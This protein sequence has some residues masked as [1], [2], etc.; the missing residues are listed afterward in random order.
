M[1]SARKILPL[2]FGFVIL[3]PL[4]AFATTASCADRTAVVETLEERFGEAYFGNMESDDGE[5]LEIYSNDV[6]QTWTILL[7]LPDR[8]LSCLV[9]S[10]TGDTPLA[11]QLARLEN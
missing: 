4:G 9:A 6:S 8:G 7:T 10:G 5:V 2:A 11:T 1:I 3:F